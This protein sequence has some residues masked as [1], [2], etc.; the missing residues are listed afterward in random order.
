MYLYIYI[1]TNIFLSLY[2]YI[3]WYSLLV[4]PIAIPQPNASSS[5]RP[6]RPYRCGD[7]VPA[8]NEARN[9][10]TAVPHPKWPRCGGPHWHTP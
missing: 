3:Y 8:P 7:V 5:G 9:G 6:L 4:F 2:I 1:Y 10:P